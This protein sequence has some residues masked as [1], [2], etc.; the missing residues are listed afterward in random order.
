M[1][2]C[3]ILTPG[4]ILGMFLFILLLGIFAVDSGVSSS[5][6]GITLDS[7]VLVLSYNWSYKLLSTPMIRDRKRFVSSLL[8]PLPGLGVSSASSEL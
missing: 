1:L 2:R 4:L 5:S 3:A 8:E 7:C 6:D